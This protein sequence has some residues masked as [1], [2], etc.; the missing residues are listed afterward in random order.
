MKQRQELKLDCIQ[1]VAIVVGTSEEKKWRFWDSCVESRNS[2]AAVD[3][4]CGNQL[5]LSERIWGSFILA[6][7]DAKRKFVHSVTV[8]V[9]CQDDTFS[10]NHRRVIWSL[11]E[12]GT[13][14]SECSQSEVTGSWKF[15]IALKNR[16]S[17]LRWEDDARS[18]LLHR[19]CS[20]YSRTY[21]NSLYEIHP[22]YKTTNAKVVEPRATPVCAIRQRYCYSEHPVDCIFLCKYLPRV[23]CVIWY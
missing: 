6:S 10:V 13:E 22:L 4:L 2:S 20:C 5:W 17:R 19:S 8:Y 18:W 23:Y 7:L 12:A 16:L 1:G 14:A 9:C 21:W 15:S 11:R 3:Y